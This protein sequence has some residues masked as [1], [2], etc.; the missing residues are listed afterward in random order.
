MNKIKEFITKLELRLSDLLFVVGFIPL[1]IFLV[2]GQLFMQY[3]N[4]DDVALKLW[5]IIPLFIILLASWGGYIFLEYKRGNLPNRIVS[6]IFIFLAF[7]GVIGVLAQPSFSSIDMIK[8]A[9]NPGDIFNI[10][11]HISATHYVFFTFD[12]VAILILIYIGLFILPKRFTNITFI[13]Y[14]GYAVIGL[15]IIVVLYSYIAEHANYI[16][17]IKA[18]LAGNTTD[19]EPGSV[20]D[21]AVKSFI[22]HRNA[23]GMMMMIGIVFCFINH[24]IEKKWWYFLIAGYLLISE[25]FSFCK[26]SIVISLLIFV[27]YVFYRLIYT[28]KEHRKRNKIILIVL[29]SIAAIVLGLTFISYVSKGK[30]FGKVYGLISSILG[31]NTINTRFFIWTNA[32]QLI[33][34]SPLYYFTGRGFGLINEMILP[35]NIANGDTPMAFPTHSSWV[36]LFAEGGIFYLLAYLLLLGYYVYISVKCFKKDPALTVALALGTLSF[37]V[38]SFIETI[39]YLVYVFMFPVFIHYHVL[40]STNKEQ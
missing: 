7:W 19:G 34:Q 11:F 16:P 24:T 2:F 22:I 36:N 17:F 35:M 39:H 4:P 20:Y 38:Y 10:D 31:G 29:L 18:L 33:N 25:V 8:S 3:P 14:L 12:I 26:T 13:K 32:Y 21:Y 23:F 27:I 15:S 6:I 37:F 1:A 5:A 9:N 30:V 28:Y 40:Y